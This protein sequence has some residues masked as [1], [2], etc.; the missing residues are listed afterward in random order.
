[1]AADHA[2]GAL[3]EAVYILQLCATYTQAETIP[4]EQ[5]MRFQE[6]V[7]AVAEDESAPNSSRV[8]A[9]ALS[10]ICPHGT[11]ESSQC[12]RCLNEA[13]KCF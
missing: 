11:S 8:I 9:Q 3:G 4:S 5:Y 13:A 12:E 6:I 10:M 7:R 1:M 2:W